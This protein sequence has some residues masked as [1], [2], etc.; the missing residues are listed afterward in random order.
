MLRCQIAAVPG[1]TSTRTTIVLDTVKETARLPIV[2]S[3]S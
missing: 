1:V 2:R 3:Q